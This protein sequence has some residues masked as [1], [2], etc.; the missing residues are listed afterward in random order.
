MALAQ[1]KE[2]AKGLCGV[3]GCPAAHSF[4]VLLP[5]GC[6]RWHLQQ[7]GPR[8]SGEPDQLPAPALPGQGP[9]W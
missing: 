8:D 2:E 5:V 4:G 7:R 6:L 9:G 3:A 1:H